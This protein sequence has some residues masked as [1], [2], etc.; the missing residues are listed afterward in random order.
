MQKKSG[1]QRPVSQW[2]ICLGKQLAV[3]P[4]GKLWTASINLSILNIQNFEEIEMVDDNSA[5]A[6]VHLDL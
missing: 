2:K 4:F 3:Q 5:V 1:Y 6:V